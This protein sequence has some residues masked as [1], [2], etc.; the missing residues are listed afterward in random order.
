MHDW[1]LKDETGAS[2]GH[3]LIVRADS[4]PDKWCLF[5]C[6]T[7]DGK[8]KSAFTQKGPFDSIQEAQLAGA[9]FLRRAGGDLR[10]YHRNTK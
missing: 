5:T 1:K 10:R 7:R 2:I 3:E 9:K 4:E 6:T 8:R